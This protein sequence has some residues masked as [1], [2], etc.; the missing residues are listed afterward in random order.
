MTL[1]LDGGATVA[2][3]HVKGSRRPSCCRSLLRGQGRPVQGLQPPSHSR[4]R[5]LASRLI[6]HS[7]PLSLS[8]SWLSSSHLGLQGTMDDVAIT[9]RNNLV[10]TAK[11]V[12]QLSRE[13][14]P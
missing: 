4:S 5:T 12:N 2:R 14:S 10:H 1:P 7:F 13:A 6:A 11:R 9:L 8:V 3:F